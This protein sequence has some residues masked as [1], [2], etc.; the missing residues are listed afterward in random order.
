MEEL[1]HKLSN[2]SDWLELD[3]THVLRGRCELAVF[4]WAK[5]TGEMLFRFLD[6]LPQQIDVAFFAR[7]QQL[8][9]I[10]KSVLL[11]TRTLPR[12]VKLMSKLGIWWV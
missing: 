5:K 4:W 10:D 7:L 8:P 1:P 9:N 6:C 11:F 2:F 3:C 12:P